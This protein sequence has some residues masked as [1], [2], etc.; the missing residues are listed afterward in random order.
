MEFN[1]K[2][3]QLRKG[4]SLTQEELAEA[5]FVSRTAVSKWESGRGYPSIDSLKEISR[6][7][8]VS[9]D[10]LICPDEIIAAAESEQKAVVGRYVSLIC[11]ALDM[12]LAVLLFIPVFGNGADAP[13]IVSLLG[14][15]GV[16][17]WVKAVF[18]AV[19]G[20]AILNGA[21][22]VI[23]AN[24]DKPT[25]SRRLLVAGMVLS[26]IGVAAFMAARQP[27]AGVVCFALLVIKGL[28][29]VRGK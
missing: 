22:G 7:F 21:C 10:E 28:L 9:I 19:V 29:I 27:Y 4:R 17:L 13:A 11:G 8:S 23:I 24:F 5:L 2:L 15:T 14:L 25:W 6:F 12:L 20:V 26:I 3:Q 1:E 16:S 18:V